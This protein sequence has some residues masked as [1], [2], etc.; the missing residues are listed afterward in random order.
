MRLKKC[1]F[2]VVLACV[3]GSCS[4]VKMAYN[5]LPELTYWWL[6]DYFNFSQSQKTTLTSALHK[7][8]EWH[9]RDQLP[10]YVSQL[11]NIQS[12]LA[13]QQISAFQTCEQIDAIKLSIRTTQTESISI[14]IEMAPLLSDKQ[15]SHFQTKLQKHAEKWKSKW[16][17]ETV[18]KQIEARLEKTEDF[19]KKVYGSL[20]DAQRS[21]L[22]QSLLQLNINPA[23]SYAEI[24]RRNDDA[25][26]T[27]SA[28]QNE[29]LTLDEKSALVKAA[30]DRLHKSPNQDYL[31]Y[32]DAI[33]KN[34]CETIANL[35]TTTNAKQKLHAKNWLQDY[36]N[37]I[38]ELQIK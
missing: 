3:I 14:I 25:F 8:H 38:T 31:T 37:Q 13:N 16:Y 36:I 22:K 12:S 6:D 18:E 20:D 23:M 7:L 10:N 19:A 33:T 2:I 28:L 30:F 35:H 34:S 15:L 27:I 9:R 26:Q 4:L 29:A 24:L 11:Q 17:Q 5:N 32:A 21:L 1:V